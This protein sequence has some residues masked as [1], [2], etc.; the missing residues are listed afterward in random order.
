[1]GVSSSEDDEED[2]EFGDFSGDLDVVVDG[3][4]FHISLFV[5]EIDFF[6]ESVGDLRAF[7]WSRFLF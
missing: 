4:G 6:S 7:H 1:M 5:D 3:L 2:S